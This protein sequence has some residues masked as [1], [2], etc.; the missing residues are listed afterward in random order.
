MLNRVWTGGEIDPDRAADRVADVLAC[1]EQWS[2]SVCW[3]TDQRDGMTGWDV[4]LRDAG[5]RGPTPLAGLAVESSKLGGPTAGPASASTFGVRRVTS[6]AD[7]AAWVRVNDDVHT[8][9]S[10]GTAADLF[11]PFHLGGDRRCAFYASFAAG[12]DDAGR[13]ADDL[14]PRQNC[15]PLLARRPPRLSRP[16]I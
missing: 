6:A 4:A 15:R 9:E 16:W 1:F 2:A 5:F 11:A 12:R 10:L 7:L 3:I 14:H 13:P 8:G